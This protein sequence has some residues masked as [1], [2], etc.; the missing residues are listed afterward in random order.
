MHHPVEAPKR[1]RDRSTAGLLAGAALVVAGAAGASAGSIEALQG[2]W[3]MESSECTGVFEKVLEE[4]RFKDRNFATDMG[5]I[6]SGSRVKGPIAGCTISQVDEENDQFSALLSCSDAVVSR[7]FSWTFRIVDA[8]H[9]ER[10][11]PT[12]RDP[13]IGYKKCEF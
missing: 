4:I 6:I 3:V 8:T 10:L 12:F 11:D 1:R 5:F 9:F 13:T 7:Q 2:A